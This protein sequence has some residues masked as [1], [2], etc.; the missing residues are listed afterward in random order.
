MNIKLLETF[1]DVI[2]SR[3]FNRTADRLDITQSTVSTRI[4]ALEQELGAPLFER[5]RSGASPTQ[6][7]VNFAQHARLLQS[8]WDQACRETKTGS[9]HDRVMH[10]AGQFSLMKSVLVDW[11]IQLRQ[12]DPRLAV[13]LQADFSGQIV[14][15]LSSGTVD[16]G[17]L[18][19][20]QYLPDLHIQQEA[21][22]KFVMVSTLSKSLSEVTP[23]GYIRTGYTT[24]FSRN[25]DTLLPELA[26]V[27]LSVGYE[28][29]SIEL[30]RRIG[31]TTYL[32]RRLA[33]DLTKVIPS[34]QIIEDAPDILQ[35]IYSTVQVRRRHDRKVMNAL[36][37]LRTIL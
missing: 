24:F 6:A 15:D 17:V 11:M 14:R 23:D 7:G 5:G 26:K 35:P 22:E 37:V 4:R 25:H 13:D 36:K 32:P 33:L 27:G 8:T 2:E 3:N 16:I 30:L 20:P 19:S 34:L 18:Y 12:T 1:L 31:G 10:L 21:V 9:D 28:G 29:L